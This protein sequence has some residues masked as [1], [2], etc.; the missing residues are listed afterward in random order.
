MIFDLCL[1]IVARVTCLASKMAADNYGKTQTLERPYT[2]GTFK[3]RL[4]E[5]ADLIEE[6]TLK[7][8]EAS[9][10]ERRLMISG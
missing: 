10:E 5:F 4:K 2:V 7:D 1:H 9:A 3:T 6:I 8:V